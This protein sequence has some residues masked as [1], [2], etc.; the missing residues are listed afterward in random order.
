MR[1]TAVRLA[2]IIPRS[3]LLEPTRVLK[4]GSS[5]PVDA[6]ASSKASASSQTPKSLKPNTRSSAFSSSTA[7]AD[8][9]ADLDADASSTPLDSPAYASTLIDRSTRLYDMQPTPSKRDAPSLMRDLLA[10]KASMGAAYPMNIRLEAPLVKA[11]LREVKPRA[12]KMLKMMMRE[13]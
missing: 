11:K 12:R 2:R 9:G 4:A 6:D 3:A 8:A 10:R 5:L 1:S 13:Q 7:D